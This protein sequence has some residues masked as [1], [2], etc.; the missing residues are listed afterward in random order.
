MY[1][2]TK[3]VQ[4]MKVTT[5]S[6]TFSNNTFIT[7][8]SDIEPNNGSIFHQI[9]PDAC[10]EGLVLISA[11]T[12]NEST[13]YVSEPEYTKD[14]DHELV[15]YHLLPTTETVRKYPALTNTKM[16]IFND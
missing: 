15:A 5:D 12:G 10:D 14:E 3:K 2:I 4:Q 13:W 16:V 6:F 8:A 11:K 1:I 9:Y 7:E